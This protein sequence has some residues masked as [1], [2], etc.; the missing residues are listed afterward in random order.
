MYSRPH[1]SRNFQA[2]VKPHLVNLKG[3]T[4]RVHVQVLAEWT[5]RY[6]PIYKFS[7][8]GLDLLVITDPEEVTKLSSRE[9][10]LP[11]ANLFYKGVNTVGTC[12]TPGHLVRLGSDVLLCAV[13]PRK[14]ISHLMS[15]VSF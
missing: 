1:S 6:G 7:L 5:V 10:S 15:N 9:L 3:L 4:E 14:C 11:K 13:Q 2:D 8:S 12:L